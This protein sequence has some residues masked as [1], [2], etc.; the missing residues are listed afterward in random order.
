MKNILL[1]GMVLFTAHTSLA[2]TDFCTQYAAQPS[3]LA[4]IDQLAT[5]MQYSYKG[6][7]T[8]S[9]LADVQIIPTVLRDENFQPVNHLWVTLHYET[10]SCQYFIRDT[11]GVVTRKNCYNTW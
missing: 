9:T 11:D 8:L 10:Y 5:A 1:A 7:C 3:Y 6:L 4:A 2:Q